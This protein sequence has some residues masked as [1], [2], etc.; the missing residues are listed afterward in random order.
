MQSR[1]FALNPSSGWIATLGSATTDIGYDVAI[2]Y[3]K[4]IWITGLTMLGG[5]GN[6]NFVANYNTNGILQFQKSNYQPAQPRG[7][8]NR[9]ITSVPFG[10]AI[11]G[12]QIMNANNAWVK[13]T[14]AGNI[15]T[16]SNGFTMVPWS[17]GWFQ[18][19][20][21]TFNFVKSIAIDPNN[22]TIYSITQDNNLFTTYFLK[23]NS[24]GQ[25]QDRYIYGGATDVLLHKVIVNSSSS[26]IFAGRIGTTGN[27]DFLVFQK[28]SSDVMTWQKSLSGTGSQ[29]AQG[30]DRD[31]SNN[32]YAAGTDSQTNDIIIAK[33]NSSGVLQWQRKVASGAAYG[34][35][36][37]SSGNSYIVGTATI[38]GNQ[39]IIILKYNT[40]GVL[41]WQ[42]FL[43]GANADN[44]YGITVDNEGF[45]YIVGQISGVGAGGSDVILAKLP[46]SGAG[47][48]TYSS[49]TYGIS[50]LTD[51]AGTLTDNTP[52]VIT[53]A[54]G[55]N[56]TL[57][58]TT[59]NNISLSNTVRQL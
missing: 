53:Q 8:Y 23:Q 24:A 55:D 36:V 38:S 20:G 14:A 42:R 2:D 50:S 7:E 34:I 56:I 59:A 1:L 22:S 48:G 43:G 17:Y 9:C 31:S 46:N 28:N 4:T 41:Q 16:T 18:G 37:E 3:N 58:D 21:F 39:Q 6:N 44:G 33:Y 30:V 26:I 19:G 32:I 15:A 51:S 29:A 52:S 40:S 57:Y 5:G 11:A 35:A 25:Q 47:T 12:G 10:G 49:I 45:V 13:F 54:T 27:H